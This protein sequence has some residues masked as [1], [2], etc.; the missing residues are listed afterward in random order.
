VI[1]ISDKEEIVCS[2]CG[3]K[4]FEISEVSTKNCYIDFEQDEFNRFQIE[5]QYNDFD[6]VGTRWS[7]VECG[8][9]VSSI[10]NK[11]L[12]ALWSMAQDKHLIT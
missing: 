9:E 2:K 5:E 1:L 12:E 10:V 6:N 8:E 4:F 7:C 11:K 3:N